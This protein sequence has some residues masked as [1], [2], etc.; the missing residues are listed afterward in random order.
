[1]AKIVEGGLSAKGFKMA[2]IVSRFNDFITSKL[3]EGALDVL[4]RCECAEDD[5]TIFKVPGALEIPPLARKITALEKFDAI[6]CLGTVI[7]GATP[8]FDF[9]AAENAKG[10]AKI[11]LDCNIP[12]VYG[13]ITTETIEQAVERAGTKHGNK[14]A[15]AALVAIEMVN[16][17]KQVDKTGQGVGFQTNK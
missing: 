6:I 16:V 13:V 3:T 9:V 1:M 8:H 17:Y 12:I 7:R 2:I 5:I 11:S 14:G 15:D 4:R 10:I